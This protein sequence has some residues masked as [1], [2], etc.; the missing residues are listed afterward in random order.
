MLLLLLLL[1][2]FISLWNV[3]GCVWIHA[4]RRVSLVVAYYLTTTKTS[5]TTT[6]KVLLL[7]WNYRNWWMTLIRHANSQT[8][9]CHTNYANNDNNKQ[10]PTNN[11]M[12]KIPEHTIIPIHKHTHTHI[13]SSFGQIAKQHN[14]HIHTHLIVNHPTPPHRHPASIIFEHFHF[15]LLFVLLGLCFFAIFFFQRPFVRK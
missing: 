14:R 12:P 9:H 6:T 10:F 15:F 5:T 13:H 11:Q 3:H 7:N 2:V 1:L 8:N 4:V